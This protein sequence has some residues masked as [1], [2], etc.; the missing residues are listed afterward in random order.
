MT[1]KRRVIRAGTSHRAI[2][3]GTCIARREYFWKPPIGPRR[4]LVLSIG[5]PVRVAAE[6]WACPFRITGL[7]KPIDTAAHGIDAV[8]ALELA[9]VGTGRLLSRSPQFRAGQVEMYGHIVKTAAGLFLPLPM[10]SIQGALENLRGYLERQE[11]KERKS[12][13]D[14]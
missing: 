14:W 8:Q 7:P 1:R 13:R 11:E 5:T 3:F 12:K 4:P 9:L 2:P 10:N 6:E